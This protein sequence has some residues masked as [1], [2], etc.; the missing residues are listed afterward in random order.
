MYSCE[1]GLQTT[2]LGGLLSHQICVFRTKLSVK[3][4]VSAMTIYVEI[5]TQE[6]VQVFKTGNTQEATYCVVQRLVKEH[7]TKGSPPGK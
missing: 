2:S 5:Y 6:K 3:V 1:C 4:H 7:P